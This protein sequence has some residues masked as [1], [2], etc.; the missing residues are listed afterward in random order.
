[1]TKE[2]F[3]SFHFITFRIKA[4]QERDWYPSPE[5]RY[6][7]IIASNMLEVMRHQINE[8]E[9]ERLLGPLLAQSSGTLGIGHAVDSMVDCDADEER[10]GV[11]RVLF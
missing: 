8:L 1:M 2:K 4:E 6:P 7:F 5:R 9:I 3:R 10:D 11:K